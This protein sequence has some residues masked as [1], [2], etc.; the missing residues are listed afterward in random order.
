M[1]E[2]KLKRKLFRMVGLIYPIIYC[3]GD[4]AGDSWGWIAAV[5]AV[6]VCLLIMIGVEYARFT[7]AGVNRWV[8]SH[9]GSFTKEKERARLSSTTLFLAACLVT[10]LVFNKPIAIA[11]ILMLVFGDPVA[12]IVGTRWG[13]TPLLSKSLEGTLAGLTACLLVAPLARLAPPGLS[14]PAMVLGALAATLAELLPW[15]VDDNLVIPLAA[16]AAM[17]AV[18]GA[19]LSPLLSGL[20][21]AAP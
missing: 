18:S 3:L 1:G 13:R 15:P 19:G 5:A 16:G 10:M 4:L 11:S 21:V 17:T 8:F 12:E 9:L 2:L 6:V 14:L 7:R 20:P